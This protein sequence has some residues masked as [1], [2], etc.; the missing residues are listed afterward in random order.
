MIGAV[1]NVAAGA[2]LGASL[3]LWSVA[4]FALFLV[5]IATL[6]IAA[7]HFWHRHYGKVALLFGL[8]TALFFVLQGGEAG[9]H[10]RL[11]YLHTAAEYVTF[12]L[13]L[14]S[15]FV[16]TG[17]IF[18]KGNLSGTPAC[19]LGILGTGALLA[20]FIGTTGASM[21]LIRPLLRANHWRERKVHLVVFFI[22]SVSN[23][24]GCLTPLGDPPLFLGF[25]KGVPF[26][27]TFQ[28]FPEWLVLNV[29]LLGVFYLYDRWRY[30][31]EEARGHHSARPITDE[32]PALVGLVNVV[33][34]LLIMGAV[35][36]Q[37]T[38]RLSDGGRLPWGVQEG[39]FV[40]I[41]LVSLQ[42]T[43]ADIRKAN[44]FTWHPIQ[45]V[46]ILF[47]AIFATM[48]PALVILKARAPQMGLDQPW[49]FFWVTG[50]LSSFLD[51]A[52]TYLTFLS[53]AQGL[54]GAGDLV[55]GVRPDLLKAISCGAV[56]MGANT[57]IGNAPNFMVKAIAE[58]SGV[59]MPSFVGYMGYS[60]AILLPLFILVTYLFFV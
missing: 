9:E 3:S 24:G 16:T 34:T 41:I 12:V 33:L 36:M 19:N 8:P 1:D 27:W 57:Y 37:G 23:I 18:M 6:P 14:A 38:V 42:V 54:G 35:L 17:G 28:L 32:R 43:S 53:V 26:G 10:W 15:L 48:V 56:F 46:A 30:K 2:A 29:A 58:E 39:L 51:N 60:A 59:R 7:A 50:F 4:P 31:W 11:E 49:Q 55:V 21:V 45:E 52:P 44:H 13:L 40:A 22:Y 47:A 25:L 20:S 5:S